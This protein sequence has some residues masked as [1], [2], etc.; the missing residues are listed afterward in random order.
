MAI[1]FEIRQLAD[2]NALQDVRGL[3]RVRIDA[4]GLLRGLLPQYALRWGARALEPDGVMEVVAR[5]S[6]DNMAFIGRRWPFQALVQV[7][8]KCTDD[9]GVLDVCD[10]SMRHLQFRR[11]AAAPVLPG[12]WSAGV[13]FGGSE[14]ERPLLARCLASLLA[15]R[16]VADGGQLMV[17]GPR[18]AAASLQAEFPSIDYLPYDQP[19]SAG[20]FL[21]GHKKNHLLR[22]AK[23]E[24][25]LVCHARIELHPEALQRLPTHFDLITPA[26]FIDGPRGPLPY[27]DLFPLHLREGDPSARGAKPALHYDRRGWL[28]Q[29][30]NKAP[31]I[32]GG[33]FAVRRSLALQCSLSETIAW[34][35]SEDVEW[36][37][38]LLAAGRLVELST[39]ATA[40]SQ[41]CKTP[42]YQRYGHHPI[43]RWTT[44]VKRVLS[45]AWSG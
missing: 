24:R 29:L 34:G 30:A 44:G 7:A 36:A 8:A 38:R 4:D 32:D 31:Y 18:H 28:R 17:C 19:S 35:E 20:R 42:G 21:V 13:I 37:R 22:H 6:R 16:P 26:V 45:G 33:L 23:N 41:T 43:Y 9:L 40:R 3:S 1:D 2:L 5:S 15:Q 12:L 39:R 10:L 14:A 25:V 27:L 11:T